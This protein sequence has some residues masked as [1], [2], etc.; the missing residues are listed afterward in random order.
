MTENK[1]WIEMGGKSEVP[2]RYKLH[3]YHSILHIYKQRVF[4]ILI[5]IYIALKYDDFAYKQN[6]I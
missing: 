4:Q 1:L 6:E 2:Q 3:A 5:Q